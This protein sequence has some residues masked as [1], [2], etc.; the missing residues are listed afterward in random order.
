MPNTQKYV[1]TT[2]NTQFQFT[3]M[4]NDYTIIKTEKQYYDYCDQL[5]QLV[6]KKGKKNLDDIELLTLLIEK[7]DRENLPVVNSNPIELIKALMKQNNLKSVDLAEILEVN[8]ST[9]SRILNYQKGLSKNSIRV[10]ANHF[11]ISQESLNQPYKLKH[12]VN[13]KFKNAALMN[14]KKKMEV[15]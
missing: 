2:T 15:V 13:K 14:T 3:K 4:A 9:V 11:A 1:I 7:W 10:L 6:S 5:E 8:K 12:E